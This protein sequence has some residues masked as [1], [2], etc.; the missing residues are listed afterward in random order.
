MRADLKAAE[1]KCLKEAQGVREE[2]RRGGAAGRRNC[3]RPK[4]D[5]KR[6]QNPGK[7]IKSA[8]KHPENSGLRSSEFP[9][10]D[11]R[12]IRTDIQRGRTRGTV[13]RDVQETSKRARARFNVFLGGGQLLAEDSQESLAFPIHETSFPICP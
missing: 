6:T 11:H 9:T 1:E 3:R 7:D 12:D 4:N 5:L 13:L 10:R 8:L 2:V